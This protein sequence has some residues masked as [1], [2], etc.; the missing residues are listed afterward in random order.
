MQ[1]STPRLDDTTGQQWR[2]IFTN[3]H[4]TGQTWACVA[5]AI[6][7]ADEVVRHAARGSMTSHDPALH[8]AGPLW[9]QASVSSYQMLIGSAAYRHRALDLP[10]RFVA[11]ED[12]IRTWL[13]APDP[14][15]TDR[16]RTVAERLEADV[17][18]LLDGE[19]RPARLARVVHEA[20]AAGVLRC[21]ATR[22]ELWHIADDEGD[23]LGHRVGLY[24]DN[25]ILA[26]EQLDATD[27]IDDEDLTGVPAATAL[28]KRTAEIASRVLA[29]AAEGTAPAEPQALGYDQVYTPGR[30]PG[31]AQGFRIG[32]RHPATDV[33]LPPQPPNAPPGHTSHGRPR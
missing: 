21:P 25:V 10:G 26:S 30:Q 2:D 14:Q 1:P 22:L 6:A 23:L 4:H 28:L 16:P 13:T 33:A 19:D 29:V 27:L 8:R 20:Q 24:R 7:H 9:T 15:S 32:T 18:F 12:A 17:D 5:V 3:P 31:W 11:D